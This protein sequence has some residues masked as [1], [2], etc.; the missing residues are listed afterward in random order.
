MRYRTAVKTGRT[1]VMQALALRRGSFSDYVAMVE[2][3]SAGFLR[4]LQRRVSP[5]RRSQ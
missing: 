3:L 5:P 1:A 4:P 2:H